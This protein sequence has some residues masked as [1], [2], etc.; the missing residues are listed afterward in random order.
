M[1][2]GGTTPYS[3]SILKSTLSDFKFFFQMPFSRPSHLPYP[4]VWTRFTTDHGP[5]RIQDVTEEMQEQAMDLLT[6]YFARD[7]PPCKYIGM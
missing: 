7:E 3:E 2:I 4:N 6:K 1:N 5:L